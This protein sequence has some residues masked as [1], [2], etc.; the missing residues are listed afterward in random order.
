MDQKEKDLEETLK[1]LNDQM[2]TNRASE[3]GC[4]T[5]QGR[6]AGSKPVFLFDKSCIHYL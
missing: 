3:A 4:L 5:I 2:A 6:I 1:D